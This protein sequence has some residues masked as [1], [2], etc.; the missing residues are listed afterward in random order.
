MFRAQVIGNLGFDA[1]VEQ[2]NGRP[3][4]SFNLAHNDRYT[5]EDGTIV[6]KSQWISCAMNGD[7]GNLLQFLKKGRQVYVEGRCSTRVFSSEKERRMVA[8]V[9]ISVDHLELIGSQ[10]DDVPGRLFDEEGIMHNVGKAFWIEN[11]EAAIILNGK[12]KAILTTPQGQRYQLTAPC[13]VSPFKEETQPAD[14]QVEV[15][16]G[17]QSE[18]AKKIVRSQ[19]KKS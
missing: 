2:N 12:D 10:S 15:F 8:G 4:V 14:E 18:E 17:E 3:F 7:G 16:D 13:W 19:K 6:E 9:N 1:R 5:K 11:Q